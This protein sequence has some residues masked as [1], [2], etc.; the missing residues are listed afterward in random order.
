[1]ALIV[2]ARF[3]SWDAAGSAAHALS[4]EGF[5]DEALQTFYVNTAGA[6]D[7][8]PGGGDRASDPDARG[9]QFGAMAGA[10][11]IGATGALIGTLVAVVSHLSIYVVV[12]AAAVGAYLGSL[13]GAMSVAGRGRRKKSLNSHSRVAD[14]PS[15][16]PGREHSAIR[17]AGVLLAVQTDAAREALVA[18]LLKDAG[19]MDVE[20]A[21]GRWSEGKWTDFDPVQPPELSDKIAQPT[22]S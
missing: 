1:M 10:A 16:T 20:R 11:V 12:A 19:G 3:D 5:P 21:V 6:H 18:R 17:Q 7:Q 22:L 14:P 2:A 15:T 9:A 4:R 13:A 8:F